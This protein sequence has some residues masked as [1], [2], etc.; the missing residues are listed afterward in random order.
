LYAESLKSESHLN[1]IVTE[2]QQIIKQA[3]AGIA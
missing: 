1:L 2:A 3:L